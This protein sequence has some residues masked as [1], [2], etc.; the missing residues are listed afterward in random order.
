MGYLNL[1]LLFAKC[2]QKNL[3][4]CKK[5]IDLLKIDVEG[6]EYSVLLGA[7]NSL[8]KGRIKAIQLEIH[9]DDLRKSD[10]QEIQTFLSNLNFRKNQSGIHQVIN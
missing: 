10:E 1:C 6:A 3:Q 7:K 2:K 9:H 5:K 4:N 8:K